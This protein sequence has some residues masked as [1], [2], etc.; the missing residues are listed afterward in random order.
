MR[1]TLHYSWGQSV[2]F[3]SCDIT[4][5]EI[6]KIGHISAIFKDRDFWFSPKT[7]YK[8]MRRTLHYSFGHQ[9]HFWSRDC[10]LT[11]F[12]IEKCQYL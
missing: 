11:I 7:F 3:W 10:A 12:F 8:I 6:Y 9:V 1:R 2:H 4:K 5:C